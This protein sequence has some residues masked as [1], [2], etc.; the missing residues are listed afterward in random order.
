MESEERNVFRIPT[1]DRREVLTLLKQDRKAYRKFQ[2]LTGELQ[3]ELIGFCMGS[4]GLKMTYDPFFKEIL[5]P[6]YHRER[7]ER[8]LSCV[9][10]E[11]VKIKIIYPNESRRLSAE[12]S[13]VIM[14]MLVELE[15][16]VLI[17]VEIQKLGYDFPGPRSACYSSDLVMREYTRIKAEKKKK[18]AY[19]DM[20]K[21][22][23]IV[24]IENSVAQFHQNDHYIHHFKQVSDT[25]L[26][27]NLLQEYIFI[28]LD[29][30]REITHNVST[31]LEAWMFFLGSDN[32]GDIMKVTEAYPEFRELYED[33]IK[34][35][36][37]PEEL[38]NM[39][40]EILEIM[41]RNTVMDMIEERDRIIKE[42]DRELQTQGQKL[43]IQGQKLQTQGQKLQIKDRVIQSKDQ[44]LL[45]KDQE[46]E[47]LKRQIEQLNR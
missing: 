32:P 24:V 33:V 43:Q 5:N 28:A 25:G 44:E 20:G 36:K 8:F 35:Q 3:E 23:T 12:A 10:E 34:F 18:F 21:V 46:I 19:R 11:K 30:F 40:S 14:D 41:D 47:K 16:G 2:K 13:L 31:E 15:S 7:L 37:K 42:K 6:V 39:F 1:Y 9:L 17:N 22:I 38:V 27:I 4:R 26:D 29:V 45:T